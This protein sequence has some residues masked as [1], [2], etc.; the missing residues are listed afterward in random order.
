MPSIP[1]SGALLSGLL[2]AACT[3]TPVVPPPTPPVP[4]I[5]EQRVRAELDRAA[6]LLAQ[7]EADGRLSPEECTAVTQAFRATHD[8]AHPR[9]AQGLFDAGVVWERCGDPAKA[10][11]A[12]RE[13]LAAAPRHAGAHNNLG[14]LQWV[15]GDRTA[16]AASFER[17]VKADPTAPAARN[18]H[19]TAL[20]ERY[21][22]SGATEDFARAESALRNALAVDSDNAV[23]H[24]NLARLYYDRG[25]LHERSYL[26]LSKLVVT[27]A[28]R[29]LEQRGTP[30]AELHNLHGL[31][32]MEDGDQVSALR[33][34]RK[35]TEVDPEHAQAHLNLAMIALRFRDYATAEQSLAKALD[36]RRH[37]RDVTAL[38]SLGVA[39]RGLRN[40]EAAENT[41]VRARELDGGDPRALYNLGILYHEHIAPTRSQVGEDAAAKL[42][43]T[44]YLDARGFFERFAKAA[45]DG[46]PK[47]VAD[48]RQRMASI[49]QFLKD[50]DAMA[51]LEAVQARLEA[52]AE[53]QRQEERARLLEVERKAREAQEGAQ[54]S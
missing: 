23:S 43:R 41:L 42:D 11:A 24:E 8:P 10:E 7:A 30:S 31:L 4:P 37:R 35:A 3:R 9:T 6:A 21:L 2:L 29:V 5:D 25:R 38:L 52:E 39:Q 1:R 17:A 46:Y 15:A 50:V 14:V 12:Y 20:R 48:A 33:A 16:A 51:E 45:G 53:R 47:E 28:T 40:Y 34:F 13:T 49:D 54:G 19:A 27:Q 26:L 22:Q 44:P 32:L 18:N 36:D